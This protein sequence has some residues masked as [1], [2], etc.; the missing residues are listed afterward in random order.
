MCLLYMSQNAIFT[1][2][3]STI[4][5][6]TLLLGCTYCNW[7]YAVGKINIVWNVFQKFFLGPQSSNFRRTPSPPQ[8]KGINIIVLFW[9][10]VRLNAQ[11]I[12]ERNI[13]NKFEDKRSVVLTNTRKVR[14]Y[15][16]SIYCT[17]SSKNVSGFWS[18]IKVGI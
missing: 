5:L 6:R 15:I 8:Q 2:S 10:R 13:R 11:N 9:P 7:W 17:G 4:L 3:L 12:A 14:T 1:Y 18:E 16:T